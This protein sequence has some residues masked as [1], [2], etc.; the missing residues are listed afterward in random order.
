MIDLST[1]FAGLK[2]KNPLIVGAGPNTK[3]FPNAIQCMQAGFGGI[4]VRSLH[5]QFPGQQLLP[6]R[7]FWNVYGDT[8]KIRK[9]FYSLQST[10]APVQRLNPKAPLGWGGASRIPSLDEWAGEV[11]KITEAAKKYDCVVIASIGW[12]GS[13]LSTEELWKAEAQSMTAAGVD[14]IQLHTAPSPATEPGRYISMDPEKYLAAPIQAVKKGTGL[15]VFAKIPVDCCDSI[16]AAVTAQ[17]AG[18]DAVVPVTRWSSIT[19]DTENEKDP[20]WRGPGIGGPWSVPIMNGLI[21]R[22]RNANQPISYVFQGSSEQFLSTASVDVPIIPSGGVRSGSDVI[23]YLI[24]GANASEICAQVILEGAGV[25]KRIEKEIQAWMQRK[26]YR[27][28]GEFQGSLRLLKHDEA[29]N[30]PQW[31]PT[32]DAATCNAC[33]RCVKACPNSA[34][35]MHEDLACIDLDYCEGCRTCYYVC[36][37]GAISLGQ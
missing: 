1:E 27:S 15:P 32:V 3:S 20:V 17:K 4:V 2:F 33:K 13:N 25:A 30:I 34:I 7:E 12:C 8:K 24:A 22:M 10:A 21:F 37:T 16:G 29:K 18:A 35:Q 11:R 31:I 9:G 19:I 36:P 14:A 28:I 6:V 5:M 23:G 26:G